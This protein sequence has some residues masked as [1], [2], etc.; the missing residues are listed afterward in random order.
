MKAVIYARTGNL[1]QDPQEQVENCKKRAIQYGYKLSEVFVDHGYSGSDKER[2]AFNE[3]VNYLDKYG[4]TTVI[5]SFLS[6][7]S[8]DS[9]EMDKFLNKYEVRSGEKLE[10]PIVDHLVAKLHNEFKDFDVEQ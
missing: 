9:E 5:T 3:M 4:N 6:V 10:K 8:R 1:E 2:P 7:I